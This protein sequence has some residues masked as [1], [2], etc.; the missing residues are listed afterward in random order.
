M[1]ND[2]INIMKTKPTITDQELDSYMNFNA[3]LENYKT[4]QAE[5]TTSRWIKA[6]YFI[7]GSVAVITLSIIIYVVFTML[8]PEATEPDA[9]PVEPEQVLPADTNAEAAPELPEP[10]LSAAPVQPQVQEKKKKSNASRSTEKPTEPMASAQEESKTYVPASPKAGYDALYRYIQETLTYPTSALRDSI[11]GVTNVSF[12][13]NQEGK[14]ERITIEQSL[15]PAF[16]LEVIRV[17]SQMPLWNPAQLNG[18][19]VPSKLSLPL[20]FEI[21][22]FQYP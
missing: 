14:A 18:K 1:R 11:K 19:P 10:N 9:Q 2:N 21:K 20:T 16:D 8:P 6:R 22:K 12:I 15:G 4:H 5:A 3:L 17:I 7:S 13:I